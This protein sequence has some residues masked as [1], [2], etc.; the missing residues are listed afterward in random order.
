MATT[1]LSRCGNA[2]YAFGSKVAVEIDMNT[3]ELVF[4]VNDKRQPI[5]VSNLPSSVMAGVCY[6]S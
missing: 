4:L 3:R 6:S 1:Q 5:V 2:E